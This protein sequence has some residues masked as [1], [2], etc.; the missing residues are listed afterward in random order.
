MI[1]KTLIL[2]AILTLPANSAW[3]ARQYR[4]SGKIQFRPCNAA[5]RGAE[6]PMSRIG[7]T[8]GKRSSA[9]TL[10]APLKYPAPAIQGEL[11]ARIVEKS[12]L[13]PRSP[14]SKAKVST[15]VWK[16]L[17]EGNGMVHLFLE[18]LRGEAIEERRFMGNVLLRGKSTTFAFVSPL[19]RGSDWTWRV[20]A[21]SKA[22]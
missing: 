5:A 3:A 16:G 13:G 20:S 14:A 15:G 1:R 11:Y 22:L 17:V 12:F 19:P 18:I 9:S 6:A 10:S 7:N 4:C 2:C 21:V 8:L